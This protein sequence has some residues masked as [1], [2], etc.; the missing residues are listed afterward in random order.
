MT[1]LR[2]MLCA[3][4]TLLLLPTTSRAEAVLS[5]AM[6]DWEGM[7]GI[8]HVEGT[9]GWGGTLEARAEYTAGVGGHTVKVRT[10][11]SDDG[12]PEYLRYESVVRPNDTGGYTI[13]AFDFKGDTQSND[14]VV[15]EEDGVRVMT[16]EWSSDGAS[17]KEEL[18][19]IDDTTVGW[20][21]WMRPSDDADWAPAMDTAWR[22]HDMM[23][24]TPIDSSLFDGHGGDVR[25]FVKTATINAP[26]ERVYG[27]FTNGEMFAKSYDPDRAELKGIIDLAIG[28]RYEW[29]WDGKMG[30]NGCQVLSYI[31]NRMV[32]FSWNAPPS[33]GTRDKHTWVVVEFSEADAGGTDVRLTHLGFAE[34]EAWDETM[35]YF[36]KAWDVVLG[37]FTENMG[38]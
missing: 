23:Q 21:V 6:S 9:W 32:S 29:L 38:E 15:S 22:K 12:G 25:H 37:R 34:G 3:L 8:W 18:R 10:W 20:K 1:R 16:T 30:S 19:V 28:G 33:L 2:L 11:V 4:A 26:V 7:L 36:E 31:P 14:W 35:A 24:A 17:I 27:A 13:Q 5:E